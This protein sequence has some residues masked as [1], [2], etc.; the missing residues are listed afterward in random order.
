MT[1]ATVAAFGYVSACQ[2][3]VVLSNG[4]LTHPAW[5]SWPFWVCLALAL[6]GVYT[7]LA[8]YHDKLPYAGR[9]YYVD[10]SSKYTLGLQVVNLELTVWTP[11]S[12]EPGRFDAKMV[13][14]L[15]N[16]SRDRFLQAYLEKMDVNIVGIEPEE[17]NYASRQIRILP[18]NFKLFRSSVIAKIPTGDNDVISPIFS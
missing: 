13:L 17:Y 18:Q 10:H 12:P 3:F 14:A 2:T 6:I 4:K 16:G 11:D 9:Q 7:F 1:V 15:V 8:S 5:W